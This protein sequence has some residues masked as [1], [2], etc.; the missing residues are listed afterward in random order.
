ME[1]KAYIFLQPRLD[2]HLLHNSN[3]IAFPAYIDTFWSC[4]KLSNHAFSFA[5]SSCL[6]CATRIDR[7]NESNDVLM[8]LVYIAYMKPLYRVHMQYKTKGIMPEFV[9]C[10]FLFHQTEIS[11]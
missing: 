10:S 7:V 8:L 6:L 11:Q 3:F 1:N 5:K 2:A 4:F 9:F